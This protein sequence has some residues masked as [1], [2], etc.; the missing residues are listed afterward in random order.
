M[1]NVLLFL[2]LLSLAFTGHTQ[3]RPSMYFSDTTRLGRPMAKDPC[4]VR[5]KNQYLLY[6]SIPENKTTGWGIGIASSTD[7]THWQKVGELTP[8]AAYEQKGLCAPGALVRGDTVHLFYQTYGN[9][10]QDAL[11]HAVSA[12]GV[13][14]RRDASN[15]IF[16]PTGAWTV[17]RAI[18]A[19][20]VPF[21]GQ[22]FL[23]F[24]TRDPAY[25]VQMQGVAT[26]PLSTGFGRTAWQQQGT[27]PVLAPPYPGRRTAWKELRAYKKASTCTYSTPAPTT[28]SPSRSA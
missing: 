8:A 4:V 15:P 6:Y 23:Y 20:V 3:Q 26:A 13:H 9:G 27:G 12:D 2:L 28:T 21:R 10:P 5:F 24:A 14:F 18:D 19:E 25:K 11:C 22:Y 1:K 17:G 7:L 16:H